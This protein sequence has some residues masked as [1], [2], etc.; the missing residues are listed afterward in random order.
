M[1]ATRIEK[2]IRIL[3]KKGMSGYA[4]AIAVGYKPQT[5]YNWIYGHGTPT[6]AVMLKLTKILEISAREILEVFADK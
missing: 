3:D 1:K 4:L 5:V 2:L 6:P